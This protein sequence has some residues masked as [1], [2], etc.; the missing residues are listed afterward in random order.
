[1][2]QLYGIKSLFITT[3]VLLLLVITAKYIIGNFYVWAL[4]ALVL[5]IVNIRLYRSRYQL[6]SLSGNEV[7]LRSVLPFR[8]QVRLSLATV[9][10]ITVFGANAFSHML[11]VS[12]GG[13]RTSLRISMHASEF[14]A[15]VDRIR[16][17]VP[18]IVVKGPAAS[19][20]Q[21]GR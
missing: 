6:I 20:L 2:K 11:V 16:S 17:A 10:D 21:N 13:Q 7:L 5:L 14:K 8:S 19:L 12:Q 4:F 18:H 3:L 15:I 1:M 9:S